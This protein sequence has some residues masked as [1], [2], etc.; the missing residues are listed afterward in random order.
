MFKLIMHEAM[1][2]KKLKDKKVQCGLCGRR[3]VIPEGQRGFCRVRENQKG[4]LISLNYGKLCSV[5]IDPIQK[6]PFFHF[7][8]GSHTISIATVGCNFRCRF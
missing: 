7:A 2:Y 4:K 8:P 5:A 3:C 1:F 6:K